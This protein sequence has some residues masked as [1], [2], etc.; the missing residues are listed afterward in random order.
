MEC[1][2]AV[3]F[4]VE[5]LAAPPLRVTVPNVVVPSRNRTV[6]VAVAGETVALKVTDCLA[7]DGFRL[8]VIEVVVLALFT[9]CVSGTEVLPVKLASPL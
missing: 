6:P 5:K 4:E 9:V 8:E 3:S 2:P 1:E 7:F